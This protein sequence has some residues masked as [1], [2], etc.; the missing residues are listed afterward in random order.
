MLWINSGSDFSKKKRM[1]TICLFISKLAYDD[2]IKKYGLCWT[3]SQV[4]KLYLETITDR[5]SWKLYHKAMTR[6]YTWKVNCPLQ[7]YIPQ[8]YIKLSTSPTI[9]VSNTWKLQ[10]KTKPWNYTCKLNLETITGRHKWKLYLETVLKNDTWTLYL[11]RIPRPILG[12]Y[13]WKINCLL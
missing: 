5:Y 9:L 13:T 6:N 4:L 11:K 7:L 3:P 2:S 10:L 8:E 12:N 1:L